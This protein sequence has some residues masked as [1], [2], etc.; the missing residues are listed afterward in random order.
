MVPS[1]LLQL[2]QLQIVLPLEKRFVVLSHVVVYKDNRSVKGREPHTVLV[3]QSAERLSL[4]G[5]ELPPEVSGNVAEDA[6]VL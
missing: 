6:R 2:V 1:H 4:I 3:Y 5:T